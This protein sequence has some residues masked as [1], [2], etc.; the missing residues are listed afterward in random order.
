MGSGAMIHLSSSI[1]TGQKLTRST[2]TD[3]KAISHKHTFYF[4]NKKSG[5]KNLNTH[6]FVNN[7]FHVHCRYARP[8]RMKECTSDSTNRKDSP[9]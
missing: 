8:W 1:K 6:I 2:D 5:L 3:S 4:L 7:C 9:P